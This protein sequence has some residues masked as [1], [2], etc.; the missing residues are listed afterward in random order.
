MLFRSDIYYRLSGVDLRVP[1]LRERHEDILELARYF[2]DRHRPTRSLRLSAAA[3]EALVSYQW[4]GNVRE[5]ERLIER[6]V[7][8]SESE[9]IEVDDLPATVRGDHVAVVGP[10]LQ[11]GETMRAWGSRYA[12]LVLERCAGNKRKAC[13]ALGISYHTL[14]AYLK[15][16]PAAP[17]AAIDDARESAAEEGMGAAPDE[18]SARLETAAPE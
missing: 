13:R 6:A 17:V 7:A 4:P 11:R 14:Q 18:V 10:S 1:S 5:L 8:L 9:V 16:Q 15:Y 3:A 2:L 12:H